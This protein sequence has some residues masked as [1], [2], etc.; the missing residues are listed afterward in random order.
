LITVATGALLWSTS[1]RAGADPA[2]RVG[3][4]GVLV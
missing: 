4:E 3:P 1:P 2:S